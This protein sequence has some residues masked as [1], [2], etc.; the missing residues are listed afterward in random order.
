MTNTELS[1]DQLKGMNGGFLFVFLLGGCTDKKD[2]KKDGKKKDQKTWVDIGSSASICQSGSSHQHPL[3]P[4]AN[5]P[6]N[7]SQK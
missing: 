1:L 5:C 4:D 7:S 6:D 3:D 2:D